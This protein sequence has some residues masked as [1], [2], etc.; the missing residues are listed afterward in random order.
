MSGN[1]DDPPKQRRNVK[2]RI[3]PASLSPSI[4]RSGTSFI[5]PAPQSTGSNGGPNL[6]QEKEERI[7]ISRRS[8]LTLRSPTRSFSQS[9]TDSLKRLSPLKKNAVSKNAETNIR[10]STESIINNQVDYQLNRVP[11]TTP[12]ESALDNFLGTANTSNK[13]T[14]NEAGQNND[15]FEFG[16]L[17][18]SINDQ[19]N[20]QTIANH[21]SLT[22]PIFPE[23]VVNDIRIRD[24]VNNISSEKSGTSLPDSRKTKSKM[25]DGFSDMTKL[26]IKQIPKISSNSSFV[27]IKDW[28]DFLREA[29]PS[30]PNTEHEHV[31][32]I[33]RWNLDKI[34]RDTMINQSFKTLIDFAEF[35]EKKFGSA[36]SVERGIEE[37][38]HMRKLRTEN[39]GRF[40][41]RILSIAHSLIEKVKMSSDNTII[42][43]QKILIEEIALRVFMKGIVD[44][45]IYARLG[46][47]KNLVEAIERASD[48]EKEMYE[49]DLMEKSDLTAN[50]PEIVSVLQRKINRCQKCNKEN[51]EY[52]DCP[53]SQ[54]IYCADST[55]KSKNCQ[56]VPEIFKISDA[57]KNCNT[58]GHTIDF[59][60][61]SEGNYCQICQL[62]NHDIN[63]CGSKIIRFC[64]KCRKPAHNPGEECPFIFAT[65]QQHSNAQQGQNN[66]KNSSGLCYSCQQPGHFAR[67]CPN[68]PQ[69]QN[70]F[71]QNFNPN[72]GRFYQ[73]RN[74]NQNNR[75]QGFQQ[76]QR[77]GNQ[78]SFNPQHYGQQLKPQQAFPQQQF[79]QQPYVQPPQ[80]QVPN[81]PQTPN[82]VNFPQEPYR[83][84]QV[85]Y[86]NYSEFPGG[87]LGPQQLA[88]TGPQKFAITGP[89]NL[90]GS[91]G[92]A[93]LSETPADQGQFGQGNH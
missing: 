46:T 50:I 28:A 71:R 67:N 80:Y 70:N 12:E 86:P 51:H 4:L 26:V 29:A 24:P 41:A 19:D 59:C 88:I 78:R 47:P 89:G 93:A 65:M 52:L 30:V 87:N 1:K 55:H 35:V 17:L 39:Y 16:D 31:I 7:D 77:Y 83:N 18:S 34:M 69:G 81:Y 54:C 48:L 40:G 92:E 61:S 13:N 20:S 79:Y 3:D 11:D 56:I 72:R 63:S 90:D 42:K 60:P 44:P 76:N 68:R 36:L 33:A 22:S 8:T 23:I 9:L 53:D 66:Q 10:Q 14:S 57:C 49:N 21:Q 32:K 5:L 74:F 2:E 25:A 84:Q 91:Q 43:G 6:A 37:L 15:P 38:Q 64:N 73:G 62:G 75:N 85:P 45:K 58:R 27:E 82:V